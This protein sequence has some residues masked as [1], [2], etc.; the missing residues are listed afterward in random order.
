MKKSILT[1]GRNRE[2]DTYN[3]LKQSILQSS[4]KSRKLSMKKKRF[5]IG[6]TPARLLEEVLDS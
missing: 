1:L 4:T 5:A 2:A 3:G 6:L